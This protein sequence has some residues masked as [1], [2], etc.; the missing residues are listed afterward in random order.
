M[1]NKITDVQELKLVLNGLRVDEGEGLGSDLEQVNI[2]LNLDEIVRQHVV[3]LK[4][5]S[6]VQPQQY[7]ATQESTFEQALTEAIS[8]SGMKI[9]H[10]FC[11]LYIFT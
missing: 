4:E 1:M 11:F 9:I 8:T 5:Q 3:K 2:E 10:F 7:D 6:F